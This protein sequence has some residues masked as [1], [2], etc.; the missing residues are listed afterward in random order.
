MTPKRCDALANY[1]NEKHVTVSDLAKAI[2]TSDV[3]VRN[4]LTGKRW[5]IA[6]E[7]L[8]ISV[9]FHFSPAE[10]HHYFFEG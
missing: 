6:W 2:G 8:A 1:M 4:K 10:I 5:W 3:N 7:I 9:Y